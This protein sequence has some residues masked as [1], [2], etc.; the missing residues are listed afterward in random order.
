MGQ[1]SLSINEVAQEIKNNNISKII[2]DENHLTITM[3]DGSQTKSAKESTSSLVEQ[4]LQLGVTT[5]QLSA[6]NVKIEI[7]LPSPWVGIFTML[8]YILPFLLLGGAFFF[9]FRQA[10]GSNSAALSFGK[11]KARMF[12]TATNPPSLLM[13]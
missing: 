11:S 4:L 3:V 7:K 13:T 9:I 5:E 10:Q 6:E 12:H 2:E 8:G 1:S